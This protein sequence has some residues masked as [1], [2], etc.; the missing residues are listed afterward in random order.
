LEKD[1]PPA[2]FGATVDGAGGVTAREVL[3][4]DA[5]NLFSIPSDR[6]GE[7]RRSMSAPLRDGEMIW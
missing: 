6:A 5:A 2:L 1:H 7:G 3:L 4:A